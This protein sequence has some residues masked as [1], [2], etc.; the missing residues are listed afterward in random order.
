MR[1]L[2]LKDDKYKACHC[3]IRVLN[4]AVLIMMYIGVIFNSHNFILAYI[5]I[6]TFHIYGKMY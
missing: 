4:K 3:R 2:D 1:F 5:Y 6:L